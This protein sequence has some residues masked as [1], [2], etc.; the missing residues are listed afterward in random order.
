[1]LPQLCSTSL[2]QTLPRLE[3]RPRRHEYL[4][5]RTHLTPLLAMG[6]LG[7]EEA[8]RGDDWRRRSRR[9]SPSTWKRLHFL[10]SMC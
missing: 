6:N 1:M 7:G 5:L 8:D 2:S 3:F 10:V 4:A 9:S